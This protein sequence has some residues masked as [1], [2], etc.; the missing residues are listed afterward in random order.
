[1]KTLTFVGSVL[2]LAVAVVALVA[3]VNLGLSLKHSGDRLQSYLCLN[4]HPD[5][6][7]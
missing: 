7:R 5:L 6:C 3:M 2:G 1:M 4:G